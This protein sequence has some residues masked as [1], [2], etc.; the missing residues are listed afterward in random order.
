MAE[1]NPQQ[2]LY[3]TTQ[4]IQQAMEQAQSNTDP[5]KVQE[6]QRLLKQA[7]QGLQIAQAQMGTQVQNNPQFQ[8]A[9]KQLEQARQ[10]LQPSGRNTL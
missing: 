3:E 1:Q 4:Q 9:Q 5:G 8:Q 2:E 10:Q 6:A 7:E